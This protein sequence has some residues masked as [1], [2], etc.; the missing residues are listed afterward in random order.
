MRSSKELFI[1]AGKLLDEAYINLKEKFMEST[2]TFWDELDNYL[3]RLTGEKVDTLEYMPLPKERE[4]YY[5]GDVVGS[6]PM[7]NGLFITPAESAELAKR[8]A[9][10]KLP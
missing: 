7:Y 4:K 5:Y 3:E 6:V 8:A 1:F 9:N 10:V 2:L